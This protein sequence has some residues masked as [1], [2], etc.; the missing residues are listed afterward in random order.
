[1]MIIRIASMKA[2][3]IGC[4]EAAK[5]GQTSASTRPITSPPN[6]CNGRAALTRRVSAATVIGTLPRPSCSAAVDR[7]SPDLSS[8]RRPPE[9]LHHLVVAQLATGDAALVAERRPVE[10]EISVGGDPL[11]TADRRRAGDITAEAVG[12]DK[13]CRR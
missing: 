12:Q 13:N 10:A 3:P 2:A 11:A 4:S 6:I 7:D 1:M 5:D 8:L 9:R